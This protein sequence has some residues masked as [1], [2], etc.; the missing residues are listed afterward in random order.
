MLSKDY[1]IF[2]TSR[3]NV[4]I[5]GH[6]TSFETLDVGASEDDIDDYLDLRIKS[7]DPSSRLRKYLI[8]QDPELEGAIVSQIKSKTGG[9]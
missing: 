2:L 8:P 6:F 5:D 4:S 7:L 9:R 1:R 3:P